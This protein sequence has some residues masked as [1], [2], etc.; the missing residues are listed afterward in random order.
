MDQGSLAFAS[1]ALTTRDSPSGAQAYSLLSPNGRYDQTYLRNYGV[2]I[3]VKA[4][5]A[6][7]A[8]SA[9]NESV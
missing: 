4:P 9:C 5:P 8:P 6:T 2:P 3:V 7:S 1:R